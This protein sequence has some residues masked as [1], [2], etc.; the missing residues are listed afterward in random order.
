MP[1][2][3]QRN[4]VEV[5]DEMVDNAAIPDQLIA[6]LSARDLLPD[7]DDDG[8]LDI[9]QLIVALNDHENELLRS[10]VGAASQE[11]KP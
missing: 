6:W 4:A 8:S 2:P 1:N 7:L 11:N 9:D 10:A 5:T 3:R